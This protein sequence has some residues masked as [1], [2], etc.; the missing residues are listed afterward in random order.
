[1]GIN[2]ESRQFRLVHLFT[3]ILAGLVYIGRVLLVEWAILTT[4]RVGMEDLGE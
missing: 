3:Y 1:L 2:R 4:E